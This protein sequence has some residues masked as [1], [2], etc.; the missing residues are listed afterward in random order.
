MISSRPALSIFALLAGASWTL[1]GVAQGTAPAASPYAAVVK[2]LHATAH[3]LNQAD[4]D[5]KGHRAKAVHEI[6]LAIHILH[7]GTHKHTGTTNKSTTNNG[8][9]GTPKEP[10]A[11]SDAQLKQ[12]LQQLKS[13]HSQ[14]NNNAPPQAIA[15]VRAAIHQLHVAL[16]IK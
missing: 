3:L 10:Q 12:A 14:L 1:A 13:I 6:H 11:V 8:A 7:P 9:T 5:Y 4:H 16:E 2:E 15:A